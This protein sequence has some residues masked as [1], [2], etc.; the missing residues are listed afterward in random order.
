MA[1]H[2]RGRRR[3]SGCA[4]VSHAFHLIDAFGVCDCKTIMRCVCLLVSIFVVRASIPNWFLYHFAH[5]IRIT[6]ICSHLLLSIFIFRPF[7]RS[8]SFSRLDPEIRRTNGGKKCIWNACTCCFFPLLSSSR[9]S[10]L[11][12]RSWWLIRAIRSRLINWVNQS[13]PER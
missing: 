4:C 13:E 7:F 3:L 12:T 10:S 8:S 11:F 5:S 2:A 9:S 6:R 1:E